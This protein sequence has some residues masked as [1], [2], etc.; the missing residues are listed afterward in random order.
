[1]NR[2]ECSCPKGDIALG[3]VMTASE[4]ASIVSLDPGPDAARVK[5]KF[6]T[7]SPPYSSG[8]G[9]NALFAVIINEWELQKAPADLYDALRPKFVLAD[10][11]FYAAYPWIGE[12]AESHGPGDALFGLEL[13]EGARAGW[14][15]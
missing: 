15:K 5:R 11:D 14:V 8:H 13:P 4:W 1:M 3:A 12:G 6:R 10:A 9:G 2:N 7:Y